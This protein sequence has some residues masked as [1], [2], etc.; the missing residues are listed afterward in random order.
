MRNNEA[1]NLEFNDLQILF[2]LYY[3]TKNKMETNNTINFLLPGLVKE[4]ECLKIKRMADTVSWENNAAMKWKGN[5][6]FMLLTRTAFLP[7]RVACWS[8]ETLKT[9]ECQCRERRRNKVTRELAGRQVGADPHNIILTTEIES[10]QCG[11][12]KAVYM[13]VSPAESSRREF[14]HRSLQKVFTLY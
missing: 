6:L 10:I 13:V 7:P 12:L 3:N 9:E 14:S 1:I 2:T 11:F 4:Q 5:V 8:T